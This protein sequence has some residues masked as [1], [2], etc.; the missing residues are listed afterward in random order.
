M[1]GTLY[2]VANLPQY[3][4]DPAAYLAANP[5]P[6]RDELLKFNTRNREW[7]IADLV[8]DVKPLPMGRSFEVGKQLFKVAACVSC[9][10]LD[11]EG[12]V[13]GPDLAKLD[14]KKQTT[15]HILTSIVEPSKEIDEKYQSY[16]FLLES[17]KAV[18][19]MII[20][21]TDDVVKIVIDPVAKGKPSVIKKSQIEERVKSKVSLMPQGLINKLSREEI[22]DLV[23]Y[24]F[25]RGDKKH[26]LFE[27]HHH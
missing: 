4:A 1:Y 19:G 21:E 15:E 25:A 27:A 8:S 24:V 17:G 26:K 7:K 5:L 12:Q 16:T 3:Q 13:F 11:H 20:E 10:K 23:A 22:L 9:H 14:A 18:T 2:V 6:I